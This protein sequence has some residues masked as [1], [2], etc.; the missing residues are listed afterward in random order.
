MRFRRGRA[1]ATRAKS[2]ARSPTAGWSSCDGSAESDRPR[3]RRP[4][5]QAE[6]SR[7]ARL[8]RPRATLRAPLSDQ[9][10]RAAALA[11]AA[12]HRAAVGARVALHFLELGDIGRP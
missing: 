6:P 9:L 11:P 2:C 4:P 1:P 7:L 10:L 5:R 3:P 8:A 12:D